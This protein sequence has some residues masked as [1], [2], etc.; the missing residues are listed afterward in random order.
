MTSRA[1]WR[2]VIAAAL[3]CSIPGNGLAK[4]AKAAQAQGEPL[5]QERLN[6]LVER[7]RPRDTV[8]DF[9]GGKPWSPDASRKLVKWIDRQRPL[10]EKAIAEYRRKPTVKAWR[11]MLD[12]TYSGG[13]LRKDELTGGALLQ[14]AFRALHE[15]GPPL[16]DPEN[17]GDADFTA[18]RHRA[19]MRLLALP[20]GMALGQ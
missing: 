12:L 2:F 9:S 14:N 1:R 6:W 16:D 13:G 20:V 18:R 17:G 7:D 15:V 10:G 4:S 3:I 5:S 11:T 19:M 8:P